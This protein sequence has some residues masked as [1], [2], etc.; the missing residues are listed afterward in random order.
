MWQSGKPPVASTYQALVQAPLIFFTGV[1]LAGPDLT[2][3]NFEPR[4]V[5]LPGRATAGTDD[6]HLS[7]GRH[8]IWPGT[9]YTGG[10]DATVIWWDPKAEGPDEVGANGRGLYR[11]ALRRSPLPARCTGRRAPTSGSTTSRS[12]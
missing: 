4:A 12:R 1:H 8:G 7:W 9:D 10:D 5:Q 3:Q 6:L 2:P 11:Y